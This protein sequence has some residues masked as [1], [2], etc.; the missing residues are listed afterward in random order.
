MERG[1][2][3]DEMPAETG[4]HHRPIGHISRKFVT[5]DNSAAV[6]DDLK[7]CAEH[8]GILAKEQGWGRRRTPPPQCCKYAVFAGHVVGPRRQRPPRWPPQYRR[9]PVDFD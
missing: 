3:L 6:L 8:I 1:E 2:A 4:S 9:A 7:R 5:D